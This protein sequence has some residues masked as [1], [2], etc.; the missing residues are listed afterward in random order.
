MI[1]TVVRIRH[2]PSRSAQPMIAVFDFAARLF[3]L[4]VLPSLFVW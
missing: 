1:P 4:L 2:A 3:M